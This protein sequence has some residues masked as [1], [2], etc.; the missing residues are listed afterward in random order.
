[1]VAFHLP[2]HNQGVIVLLA[3]LEA[4]ALAAYKLSVPQDHIQLLVKACV[5]HVLQGTTVLRDHR[6]L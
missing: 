2:V 5:Y 4:S 3:Q 1:M 6:C